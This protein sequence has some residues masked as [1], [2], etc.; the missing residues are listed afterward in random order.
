MTVLT[1]D[2]WEDEYWNGMTIGEFTDYLDSLP[3]YDPEPMVGPVNGQPWPGS[4]ETRS[5]LYDNPF[6]EYEPEADDA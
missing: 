2:G 1:D 3:E 5:W 4:I 6:Y